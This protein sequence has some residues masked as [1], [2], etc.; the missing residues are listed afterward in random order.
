MIKL[1]LSLIPGI[2][3]DPARRVPAATL[4]EFARQTNATVVAEGIEINA[5]LETLVELGVGYGQGFLLGR[6]SPLTASGHSSA[7]GPIP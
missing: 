3:S 2:D 1:D 4:L 5:W 7:A 6:P